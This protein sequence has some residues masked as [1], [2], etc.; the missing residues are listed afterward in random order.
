MFYANRMC[1]LVVEAGLGFLPFRSSLSPPL[2]TH[3]HQVITLTPCHPLSQRIVLFLLT[4]LLLHL[5]REKT[6]LT[7]S[8][9]QYTG[10]EFARG[11]CGVSVIRSGEAMENALRECCQGIKIGKILVQRCGPAGVTIVLGW[12]QGGMISRGQKS[13]LFDDVSRGE[14]SDASAELLYEKLPHDIADR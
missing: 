4:S 3:G 7:P 9:E 6:V 10:V 2:T 1:R 5:L 13:S 12:D 11:I 8:G 14:G